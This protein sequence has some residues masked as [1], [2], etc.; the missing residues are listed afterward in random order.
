MY[1]G[2]VCHPD[3]T[4]NKQESNKALKEIEDKGKTANVFLYYRLMFI[5]YD[6]CKVI[7]EILKMVMVEAWVDI[8]AFIILLIYYYTQN[9]SKYIK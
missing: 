8:F 6:S 1:D 7:K 5:R 9:K 4:E 2:I 3:F